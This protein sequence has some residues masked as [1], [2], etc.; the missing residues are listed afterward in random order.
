MYSSPL[1]IGLITEDEYVE[2]SKKLYV[3]LKAFWDQDLPELDDDELLE[4]AT[5]DWKTDS[6]G[7][8]DL[9]KERFLLSMFQLCDIWTD[10]ID[11]QTVCFKYLHLH[12]H[13]HLYLHLHLHFYTRTHMHT[14]LRI[15]FSASGDDL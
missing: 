11:G 7:F 13:A 9:D 3:T 6:Q 1:A 15:S 12:K 4:I 2:L 5:A 14:V 8:E 10:F